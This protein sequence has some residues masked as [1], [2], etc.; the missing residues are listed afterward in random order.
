M[1]TKH[2][3]TATATRRLLG[4]VAVLALALAACG[5]SDDDDDASDDPTTTTVSGGASTT[6]GG[7]GGEFVPLPDVPGVT[8]EEI[9]FAAFGTQAN[10]PLGTCVLNCYTDGINAYFAFRNAEGGVH[11]RDLVLSTVLDDELANNQVRAIEIVSANDTFA[12]FSATQ[13][14]SGWADVANAGIPLYS[15]GI[16]FNEANGLEGIFNHNGMACAGCPSRGEVYVATLAGATRVAS[17]GYGVSQNS[18]DCANAKV[19]S[20]ELFGE[21]TGLEHV[22]LND[23]LAFGLPNGIAPEVTAMRDAGVDFIMACIDLNGQKTLAQ[24]LERQGMGDVTMLHS[25]TYDAEFVREAGDLFEGDYVS[26]QTRP[27]EADPGDSGLADFQQWM[28]ETG[29]E[30]SEMAMA[31]WINADL[32]YQGLLAAGPEFDRQSVIDATNQMTDY[33]ADGLLNP[34]NWA[35]GGHDTPTDWASG[36]ALECLSIVQVVGG[37]FELVGEPTAPFHCW[38]NSNHDWSEPEPTNFE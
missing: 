10:N 30:I 18:K 35:E 6:A 21:E 12:A 34:I 24:E 9:R 13:I 29:S 3:V 27:F 8:D 26:V 5:N 4:A 2:S 14:A 38:D 1:A 7:D 25:N 36:K 33:T 23:E 28:E 19:D 16:H 15:W 20:V 37:E 22:Y 17:L 11:A 32:A 31:G